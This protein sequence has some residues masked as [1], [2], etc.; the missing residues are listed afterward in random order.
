M[1]SFVIA[2]TPCRL[3]ARGMDR[4]I[5]V[6]ELLQG[7]FSPSSTRALACQKKFNAMR[8]G[9]G[10]HKPGAKMKYD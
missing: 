2:S 9:E 8:I 6:P 3:N 4:S 1:I 5:T 7:T 10:R